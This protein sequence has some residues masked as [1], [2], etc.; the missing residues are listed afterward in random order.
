MKLAFACLI[1]ILLMASCAVPSTQTRIAKNS[2]MYSKLSPEHRR[3]VAA[4]DITKGM[5]KDAVYLAWGTPSKIYKLEEEG[6]AKERWIYTRSQPA[7]TTRVGIGYGNFPRYG[8][9]GYHGGID[10]GPRTVYVPEKVAEVIFT[11]D[12]VESWERK[13]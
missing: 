13:K 2:S 9:W 10:C 11:R 8:R 3:L 4:G 5:N 1:P 7:Y 6:S 12:K